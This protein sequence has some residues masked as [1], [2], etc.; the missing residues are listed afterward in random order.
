MRGGADPIER[1]RPPRISLS[2]RFRRPRLVIAD[3]GDRG[4]PEGL[5]ERSA[6]MRPVNVTA[7]AA[8]FC[9]AIALGPHVACAQSADTEAVKAALNNF[10]AAASS[11]EMA[12]MEALWV[13][14]PNVVLVLPPDKIP[15]DRVG[16]RKERLASALRLSCGMERFGE[17]G[18]SYSNL[19]G[20]G[21]HHH[22][23][24]HPGQDQGRYAA[25]LFGSLDPGLCQTRGPLAVGGKSRLACAR[26]AHLKADCQR[27]LP[28]SAVWQHGC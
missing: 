17:R 24:L 3:S 20:P 1:S 19:S 14:E 2:A 4:P 16:S 26:V 10:F 27:A 23:C 18:P 9:I 25:E 21:N 15:L 5:R 12:K 8:F 11:R 13:R 22:S 28:H 7:V 6:M